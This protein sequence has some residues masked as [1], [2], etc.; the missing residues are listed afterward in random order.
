MYTAR[1]AVKRLI[2]T[3]LAA[4]MS[5]VPAYTCCALDAGTP[6][7][8]ETS[9]VEAEAYDVTTLIATAQFA[10]RPK[11]STYSYLLGDNI[12]KFAE[13]CLRDGESECVLITLTFP[14]EL[15]MALEDFSDEDM[16]SLLRMSMDALESVGFLVD[17]GDEANLYDM[18]CRTFT[19]YSDTL[20][21]A[22]WAVMNT[23]QAQFVLAT[24]DEM[25]YDFLNT[26]K[27]R[28]SIEFEKNGAEVSYGDLTLNFPYSVHTDGSSAQSKND[29][30]FEYA[31]LL[32]IPDY[33]VIVGFADGD[34]QNDLLSEYLPE[35]AQ[36]VSTQT[37]GSRSTML[38]AYDDA[39]LG[40]PL[41][42]RLILMDDCVLRMEATFDNAGDAF[43]DGI[44]VKA[45]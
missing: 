29:L 31:E 33:R 23:R 43:M 4:Y 13:Y 27:A 26:I 2:A 19:A 7:S 18:P 25:G 21:Y 34:A 12:C 6:I 8:A 38:Y 15:S 42:G 22:G 20:T 1:R 41:Q 39:E 5:F 10:S 28:R 24:P 14:D 35:G 16:A 40:K 45:R 9:A 37:L 44:Y 32:Q 3:V 11:I 17:A 30:T 36:D